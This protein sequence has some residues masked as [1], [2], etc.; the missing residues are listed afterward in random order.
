M[1]KIPGNTGGCQLGQVGSSRRGIAG[2]KSAR[3]R[4]SSATRIQPAHYG[5]R[6]L[7]AMK[8]RRRSS[9]GR[10][11]RTSEKLGAI[12][13][14]V[15]TIGNGVT[16]YLGIAARYCPHWARSMPVVTDPPYGIAHTWKGGFSSK[17]R[18]GK[19]KD[20]SVT[21]NEWDDAAPDQETLNSI[22]TIAK[23]CIIWG[24]NYFDLPRSRWA[25]TSGTN[26]SEVSLWRRR[27]WRGQI[28]IAWSAFLIV[29]IRAGPVH[30]TQ[31][32]LALNEVV[33]SKN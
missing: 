22:L 4:S 23:D 21:R 11:V 10:S 12:L 25:C 19:A 24:G 31:K 15:E 29:A 20:A 28:A 14:R 13:S 27:S 9:T 3:P 5:P 18:W 8:R 32:P 17:H 26:R 33:R 30:P 1:G 7:Q 2:R 16:L 6:S